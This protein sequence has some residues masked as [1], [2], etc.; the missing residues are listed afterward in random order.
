MATDNGDDMDIEEH[1]SHTYCKDVLEQTSGISQ[2]I[3]TLSTVKEIV[4]KDQ[5]GILFFTPNALNS[6]WYT[7]PAQWAGLRLMTKPA[8]QRVCATGPLDDF[9][10]TDD[11]LKWYLFSMSGDKDRKIRQELKGTG[12]GTS[13]N[14][15]SY[16]FA[17]RVEGSTLPGRRWNHAFLR[18][19]VL[20]RVVWALGDSDHGA[21]QG[22]YQPFPI[23]DK[24]CRTDIDNSRNWRKTMDKFSAAYRSG[25]IPSA[26][27][28]AEAM[29]NGASPAVHSLLEGHKHS[30]GRVLVDS[31]FTN[32]CNVALGLY[33]LC[34]VMEKNGS[35]ELDGDKGLAR[36]ML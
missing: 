23:V 29:P 9:Y 13:Y 12:E 11:L 34:F 7:R 16:A 4:E 28:A 3:L 6:R 25:K 8:L 22:I 20:D 27:T 26:S 2:S 24:E 33:A 35:V 30:T 15:V 18:L 32:F 17:S 36:L 19:I 21:Y 5:F 10:V 14:L 31:A 1:E